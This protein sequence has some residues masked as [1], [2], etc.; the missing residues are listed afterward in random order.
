MTPPDT[1]VCACVDEMPACDY[2]TE[3]ARKQ[4]EAG[5]FNPE[6]ES[7]YTDPEDPNNGESGMC[8]RCKEWTEYG[9]SCCGD[10]YVHIF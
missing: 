5:A 1:N 8:K 10:E 3:I 2:C 7:A 4:Y 9:N 6:P